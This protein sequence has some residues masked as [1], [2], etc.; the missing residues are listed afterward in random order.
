MP[1]KSRGRPVLA[2]G[3]QFRPIS[4]GGDQ[5]RRMA[6]TKSGGDQ[7]IERERGGGQEIERGRGRQ[8]PEWGSRAAGA[9]AGT[10]RLRG[11]SRD[12]AARLVGRRT[13][14]RVSRTRADLRPGVDQDPP[15]ARS[16]GGDRDPPR[17]DSRPVTSEQIRSRPGR[18]P[19]H[20]RRRGQT[21]TGSGGTRPEGARR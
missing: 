12:G 17:A 21:R 8:G 13:G 11:P 9:R 16:G 19:S 2:A 10:G 14:I 5:V 15:R 3:N 1:P 18:T 7:G 20:D 4:A 6:A